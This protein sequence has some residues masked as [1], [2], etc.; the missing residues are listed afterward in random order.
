MFSWNPRCLQ[1]TQDDTNELLNSSMSEQQVFDKE[2]N[3][4]TVYY[5]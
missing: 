3:K 2:S 5:N 1:K 4:G